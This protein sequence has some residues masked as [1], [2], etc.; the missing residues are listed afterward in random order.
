[1]KGLLDELVEFNRHSLGVGIRVSPTNVDLAEL[2][3]DELQELGAAYPGR[4][5][6][7]KVNGDT[8][9]CW[10]GLSLQR[11]RATSLSTP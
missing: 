10:D 9:G 2:F 3:A 8:T 11:L 4:E 1:M 6:L 7:L 5:L